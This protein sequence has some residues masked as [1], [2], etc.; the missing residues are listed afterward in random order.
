[1]KSNVNG[2]RSAVVPVRQ[3]WPSP[4][5][6]STEPRLSI[7]T[8]N[9]A[10]LSRVIG[11]TLRRM[12]SIRNFRFAIADLQF[13]RWTIDDEEQAICYPLSSIVH[14]LWSKSQ[15]ANLKSQITCLFLPTQY[16]ECQ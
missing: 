15:I 13:G 14:R 4:K 8:P 1:M 16:P 3:G 12:M 5:S 2:R 6:T 10:K 9:G 11:C 7:K